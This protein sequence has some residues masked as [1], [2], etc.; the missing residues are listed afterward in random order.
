MGFFA[1]L[2]LPPPAP[3]TPSLIRNVRYLSSKRPAAVEDVFEVKV[4][5]KSTWDQR[6]CVLRQANQVTCSLYLQFRL[7]L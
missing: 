2:P 3:S 4:G 6:Y 5:P 1:P 7:S